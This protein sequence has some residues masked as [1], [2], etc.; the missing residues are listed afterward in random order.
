MI[1]VDPEKCNGCGNCQTNCPL[2]AIVLVEDKAKIKE[3]CTLCGTCIK[4]CQRDA[5]STGEVKEGAVQCTSCGVRCQIPEGFTGACKRYLNEAG[6]LSRDRPLFIPSYELPSKKQEIIKNPLITGVGAGTAYPDYNPAPYIVRKEIEGVDVVTAV[7]EAHVSYSSMQIKI[8]TNYHIGEEGAKVKSGG[9]KIG[10]VT[11]E[12]Y[13]SQMLTIGGVNTVKGK[14]GHKA[15]KAMLELGNSELVT[16]EIENGSKL[17]LQVGQT[18]II[19]GEE[20]HKMRVGC[21]GANIG[22][23]ASHFAKLVDEVIVLDHHI[24]GLFTK[25]P[26][27]AELKSYSGVVPVGRLSTSGRYFGEPGKG[28]GGTSIENPRQAIKDIDMDYAWPGMKILVAETTWRK[29]ALFVLNEKGELEERPLSPE[30]KEMKEMIANNCE[31]AK[32][33]VLYYAGVGGSARAGITVNPIK[34]TQAVHSQK[35][36]LTIGGAP[37]FVF[38][39]GGITFLADVEKMAPKPFSM[40]PTPAIVAP[41]EYTIEY[42][43]YKEIGG[44]MEAVKGCNEIIR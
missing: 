23:F 28:W 19:D 43:D 14:H 11:T 22:L 44:H 35:A 42:S 1:V 21:G 31:D 6:E 3:N 40:I 15:V 24:I 41:V 2:Q 39:G 37:A 10:M 12:Q 7:T 34:L 26:A 36:N 5:L 17:E 4:F 20:D 13:G 30:I 33:S 25:H 9:K 38:P 16:L 27:G 8:D 32:V 18:P 29:V